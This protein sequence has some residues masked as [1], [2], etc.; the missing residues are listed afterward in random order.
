VSRQLSTL[1][2]HMAD[3]GAPPSGG[4][5]IVVGGAKGG[6]GTTTVAALLALAAAQ[7]G[8]QVLVVDG[9]EGGTGVLAHL[10]GRPEAAA[11][12]IAA[13]RGRRT[14][15]ERVVRLTPSLS[16]LPGGR[17]DGGELPAAERRALL[18]RVATLVDGYDLVV[19]DGGS[20][21]ETVLAACG[22]GARRLIAVAVPDRITAAATFALLKA[23]ETKHPALPAEV[24]VNRACEADGRLAF[25]LVLAGAERFLARTPGLAA[26]VPADPALAPGL[27][28][29]APTPEQLAAGPAA[30]ALRP[31][32]DR[33]LHDETGRSARSGATISLYRG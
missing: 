20:R 9:D 14:P 6:V 19:V 33:L 3:R 18:R 7:E 25:E 5:A 1:R 21:L 28:A 24:V 23:A 12:G 10:L 22:A 29:P 17:G 8:Q 30:H 16:L 4:G 15:A 27:Q 11:G 31:L 32:A 2:R 13:L 26:V